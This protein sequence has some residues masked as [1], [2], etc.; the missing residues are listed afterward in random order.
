MNEKKWWWISFTVA[1]FFAGL[2]AI[3]WYIEDS[4]YEPNECQLTD[5][6]A[7][8]NDFSKKLEKAG[9]PSDSDLK[10]VMTGV[11]IQSIEFADANDVNLTGY[12]WQRFYKTDPKGPPGV[13]FPEI[14]NSAGG[15]PP[16]TQKEVYREINRLKGVV[17]NW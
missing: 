12:V 11:F 7:V 10:G 8:Y 15:I 5:E 3:R 14:V 17:L 1:F 13:V 16:G 4:V 6:L 9:Y 2:V